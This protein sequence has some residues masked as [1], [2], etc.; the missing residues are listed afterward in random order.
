MIRDCFERLLHLYPPLLESL[1][2][3]APQP[4]R[5]QLDHETVVAAPIPR[6]G[7]TEDPEPE[8]IRRLGNFMRRKD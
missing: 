8:P 4:E 3:A 1:E 5:R 6:R 2:A 7:Q